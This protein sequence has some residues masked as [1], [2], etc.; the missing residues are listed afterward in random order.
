MT[1]TR[2]LLTA[3]P[4]AVVE[5]VKDLAVV[6]STEVVGTPT[7]LC[8]DGSDPLLDLSHAE[9]AEIAGQDDGVAEFM[10]GLELKATH[11]KSSPYADPVNYLDLRELATPFRLFA[12]ALTYFQP[13]RTDYALA[14]YM[15]SFNWPAVFSVLRGLCAQSGI[16]WK[17]QEF[18]LVIFRSKLQ[19]DADRIKLG[20]LD[21]KSH[22]EAC[23]SGGLLHYW[24]G[25]PD[26]KR[27]NLATCKYIILCC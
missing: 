9:P 14:P 19:A 10:S 4:F 13:I 11:L 15:D 24:F 22:E 8:N 7:P 18:Y 5:M 1:E 20:E 2:P 21:K 25:S 26:E 27:Q 6:A 16:Q 17:Y 23:A 3:G 12:F